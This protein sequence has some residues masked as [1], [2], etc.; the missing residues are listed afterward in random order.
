MAKLDFQKARSAALATL[1]E[2]CPGYDKARKDGPERWFCSPLREDREEGSFSINVETGVFFDFASGDR[3]D[4][5]TLYAQVKGVSI[6]DAAKQLGNFE[7]PEINITRLIERLER[8]DDGAPK[9][10]YSIDLKKTVEVTK[11]WFYSDGK[12]SFWVVRHDF[13]K[14]DGERDKVVAPMKWS[15]EKSAWVLGKPEMP[16][17]GFPLY[18]LSRILTEPQATIVVT[19]GE[20]AADAIP[21]PFIGVTSSNGAQSVLKTDFSTLK[22]RRVIVWRDNDE[23]GK[24]YAENVKKLISGKAKEI[25]EV[26]TLPGWKEKDDAADRT[27]EEIKESLESSLFVEKKKC[28][29]EFER[30]GN[31]EILPTQWIIK[32]LIEKDATVSIYG[33]SGTGKSFVALS[34]ACSIATGTDF[35][36]YK[37]KSS[38]PVLYI[39][40]EGFNGI[41]KRIR[42][43][44]IKTGVSV[45][46][47]PLF[48]SKRSACL[49]DDDIMQTVEE[50]VEDISESIGAPVIVIFDTWARNMGGNENDTADTVKAISALDKIRFKYGCT[51][52]VVHHTGASESERAR[53]STALRAALEAEYQI[54][55]Q[56]NKAVKILRLE[57]K[58]MKDGVEPE[59][60][61]FSFEYVDLG[62]L[63]DDGEMVQSSYIGVCPGDDIIKN[64]AEKEKGRKNTPIAL[65]LLEKNG[66]SMQEKEF[67][68]KMRNTGI[69]QKTVTR[70]KKDLLDEGKIEIQNNMII[71]KKIEKEPKPWEK[72]EIY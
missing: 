29:F 34:M 15:E 28:S 5:L 46:D 39:A 11:K 70:V 56:T 25:R 35:F 43:W 31:K 21:F 53:G 60:L 16:D 24:T 36:D 38:G 9:S 4:I 32:G 6:V 52:M 26:E 49:C 72:D 1:H 37:T 8:K 63:D 42:A 67:N 10:F 17:Q 51:M 68:E 71:L 58:K 55:N 30:Y 61:H 14:A 54:T 18:N 64:F 23:P 66:G 13:I 3:G 27:P 20:K 19:E 22:G 44:E 40:G 62:I 65:D 2:W 12:C 47:S 48:I 7:E 41:S 33:A 57:N 45:K 59:P 69:V 50:S